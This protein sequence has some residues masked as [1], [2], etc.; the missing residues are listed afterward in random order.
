MNHFDPRGTEEVRFFL[1]EVDVKFRIEILE[2]EKISNTDPFLL[3]LVMR[4]KISAISEQI[5]KPDFSVV[6]M[7]AT[8]L[9]NLIEYVAQEALSDYFRQFQ[10][11]DEQILNA[12]RIIHKK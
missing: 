9:D 7:S 2:L 5:E 8:D 1:K 12:M 3:G 4:N 6:G 11:D 10:N